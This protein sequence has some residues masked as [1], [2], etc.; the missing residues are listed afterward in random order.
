MNR[1]YRLTPRGRAVL[2]ALHMG[3]WSLAIG[4]AW[5]LLLAAWFDLF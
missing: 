2:A 5:A 1:R 3:A 4:G